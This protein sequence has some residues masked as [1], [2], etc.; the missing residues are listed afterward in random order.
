MDWTD[1]QL[2]VLKASG[3]IL[4]SASAGSGKTT[5]MV[6]KIIDIITGGTEVNEVLVLTYTNASAADMRAKIIGKLYEVLDSE[7]LAD[8]VRERVKTQLDNLSFSDIG[9][10]DSFCAKL[11]HENFE[12]LNISP[13]LS[14]MDEVEAADLKKRV[15]E[16][17]IGD[18][19]EKQSSDFLSVVRK[20]SKIVD[21]EPLANV[22]MKVYDASRINPSPIAFKE[23]L[24][25]SV[26]D[27]PDSVYG[28]KI[29]EYYQSVAADLLPFVKRAAEDY[30]CEDLES[31]NKAFDACVQALEKIIACN[32]PEKIAAEPFVLP[33]AGRM[34]KDFPDE[35]K[36]VLKKVRDG[37]KKYAD[38]LR[39]KLSVDYTGYNVGEAK[40]YVN[41]VM[42]L[43]DRFD[44]EYAAA[45]K[46]VDK[47]DFNDLSQYAIRLLSDAKTA[48]AIAKKYRFIFIDEYQDI[49]PL[50]EDI[51][52]KLS[53]GNTFMVGD[54]K[55]GIYS[56]RNAEPRIMNEK[57]KSYLAGG[58]GLAL[59]ITENFRSTRPILSFCDEVFSS[60]LTEE[61]GGV[62]YDGNSRFITENTKNMPPEGAPVEATFYLPEDGENEIVSCTGV[63]SV[64]GHKES[65]SR[66]EKFGYSEG[67]AVAK[68]I[69]E[70]IGKPYQADKDTIKRLT[71]ADITVLFRSRTGGAE[72][73]LRALSDAG[74]PY[75]SDGFVSDAGKPFI[76]QLVALMRVIDNAANDVALTGFLLSWFAGFDEDEVYRIRA[77]APN[78]SV[79]YC[80][81]E[82]EKDDGLRTKCAAA[83]A[84]IKRWRE[85]AAYVT[86]QTLLEEVISVTGFDAYT[87]AAPS[88]GIELQAVRAFV[89]GIGRT[90]SG[91]SVQAFLDYYDA[92]DKKGEP[93]T[94]AV[95]GNAVKISTVHASKGL[96]YPVVFVSRTDSKPHGTESS[97][98][99]FDKD[100]GIGMK[101]YNDATRSKKASLAYTAIDLVRKKRE[102]DENIR[103]F[104]VALT[105][106]QRFL[107]VTGKA[108]KDID[109]KI[110]LPTPLVRISN[111]SDL[112]IYAAAKNDSVRRTLRTETVPYGRTGA[113]ELPAVVFNKAEKA[114]LDE[115]AR[116]V[117]FEYGYGGA[118]AVSPKYTVSELN[119]SAD[120]TVYIPSATGGEDNRRKGIA[121]HVVMEN[122]DFS[123]TTLSEVNELIL[124]LV[125]KGV[126][127]KEDAELVDGKQILDCINNDVIKEG[128]KGEYLREK[129]FMLR[130][131]ASE[132]ADCAKGDGVLIQGTADLILFGKQTTVI[133]FKYS[134]LDDRKLAEKYKKQLNLYEIAV[135]TAFG[136]KVDKKL[137]YSFT[138]GRFIE[139][140]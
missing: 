44:A 28:Q 37:V 84:F 93:I 135:E 57:R 71:Y 47:I 102:N 119:R 83:I 9:T 25:Q 60:I 105:R 117:N 99:V 131:D 97:D 115:I 108:P 8:D 130:L 138:S 81:K 96:E 100:L 133:D 85:R 68:R 65:E 29:L 56:F 109:A 48:D 18:E 10:M 140:N 4:V 101:L 78:R 82:Y 13:T 1:E 92:S 49:N 132:I 22:V 139:I 14:Q 59:S 45:K 19:Y 107:F 12:Y 6:K 87:L 70:L 62:D 34:P 95:F 24:R 30:Y 88:G 2:S 55:Q 16:K 79:Y 137:L 86:V 112:L 113:S 74:V 58:D 50:Q 63:Y 33:P 11:I 42:R 46:E 69:K 118:I 136:T 104:Y 7:K 94:P 103:L 120:D 32:R 128:I 17:I 26:T 121:Y 64:A 111:F 75:V 31:Y 116:V 80:L 15:M 40:S 61:H 91:N 76:K 90:G 20:M 126:L 73:F 106:A 98:I 124:K 53:R 66:E 52:G 43:V 38:E 89:R 134:G 72:G 125:D 67:A 39:S 110:A 41:L 35:Y 27:N 51:I 129:P 23:M 127:T 123:F 5:V 77:A 3:N 54:G 114:Y 122:V 36:E 21:D